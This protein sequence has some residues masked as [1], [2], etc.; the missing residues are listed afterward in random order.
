MRMKV[1]WAVTGSLLACALPLGAGEL[2][3]GPKAGARLPGSFNVLSVND[4]ERPDVAGRRWDYVEQYGADP[5]VLVFARTTSGPLTELLRRT[6]AEVARYKTGGKKVHVLLVMLSDDDGLEERLQDFARV[7]G[8]KHVSLSRD[9]P[10]GP[11]G[12]KVAKEADVTVLLYNRRTVQANHAF[13]EAGLDEKATVAVLADLPRLVADGQAPPPAREAQALPALRKARLDQARKSYEEAMQA[14][15]Q[16]RR[17]GDTV[18]PLAR[19]EDVYLWSVRWL[20]AER[21]M[22]DRKEDR[23]AALEAHLKR[24]KELRQRVTVMAE[25]GLVPGLDVRAAEFYQAEAELWL[26]QA[27]SD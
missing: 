24:M 21:G 27:R 16:T 7:Q 6:D 26:A 1:L 4:A 22:S 13:P 12:W 5:A 14:S 19:A 3:S 9:N 17:V 15:Q 10:A 25:G 11:P 2:N 18:L 8:F 23:V 20:D